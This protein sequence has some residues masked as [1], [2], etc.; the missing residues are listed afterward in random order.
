MRPETAA[1]RSRDFFA[2]TGILRVP[3]GMFQWNGP[4]GYILDTKKW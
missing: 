2:F 4:R 3:L 1:E